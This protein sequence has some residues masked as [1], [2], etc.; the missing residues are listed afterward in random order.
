MTIQDALERFLL[1]L[2]ADG[3]SPHTI[4]QYRRHVRL[5]TRWAHEDGHC[6][7][8][9]DRIAHEDV[10]RFLVSYVATSRPDGKPKKPTA[11]NCLRASL[12]GFFKYCLEAG[13]V[14][15]NPARM[16]RRAHCT[17]PPPRALTDGEAKKLMET[18]AADKTAEGKRDFMLFDLMLRTGI[19][20]GSA[21]ALDLADIDL[22]G[23][24]L[25]LRLSKGGRQDTVYLGKGIRRHV[26]RYIKG[27]AAG[28]LFTSSAGRRICDRHAQ[29]RFAM[30]V[31][32][33]GIT[34]RVSCHSLRHTCAMVLYRKTGDILLVKEALRHRSI[35]ST[36][37]YAHADRARLRKV[38]G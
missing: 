29:R 23:G 14:R 30:W 15:E 22:A 7:A 9:V 4:A 38:M 8:R 34:R 18:M 31:K 19:R 11:M 28:P 35:G 13:I 27:R 21:L 20:L 36:L 3:R 12:R 26:V 10:A 33:A 6:G 25:H 5:F 32:K 37:V 2:R 1:Q 17:R 24:E 16:V